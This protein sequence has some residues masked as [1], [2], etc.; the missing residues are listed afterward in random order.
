MEYNWVDN[1]WAVSGDELPFPIRVKASR[2]T[3]FL[4]FEPIE[5]TLERKVAMASDADLVADQTFSHN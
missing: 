5:I 4:D 2:V 3:S 1:T